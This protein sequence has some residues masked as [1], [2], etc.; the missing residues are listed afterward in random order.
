MEKQ[1]TDLSDLRL[2]SYL[3]VKH[4]NILFA[5]SSA[6]LRDSENEPGPFQQAQW[7]W[8]VGGI[9]ARSPQGVCFLPASWSRTWVHRG[10]RESQVDLL[11]YS[12]TSL[13][14][15]KDLLALNF[16]FSFFKIST[17]DLEA[18]IQLIETSKSEGHSSLCHSIY[19]WHFFIFE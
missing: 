4:C 9:G 10:R 7:H 2:A 6:V 13:V 12:K 18:L 3:C 1:C 14:M 15:R 19:L 5:G 16:G 11:H 17:F 8:T